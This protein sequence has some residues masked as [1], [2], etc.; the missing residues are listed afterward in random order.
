MIRA[1]PFYYT[2]TGMLIRKRRT[3]AGSLW[4]SRWQA[5]KSSGLRAVAYARQEGFDPRAAYRWRCTLRRTGQW[6]DEAGGAPAKPARGKR[7]VVTRFARIA[8]QEV[9]APTSS[10]VLAAI[11]TVF[12]QD[13]LESAIAQWR[14][15][16]E[17][18]RSKFPK[19][20]ELMDGAE[21][22]G[23]TDVVGIFSNAAAIIRLVGA[24]LLE[25]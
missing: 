15:V 5:W 22:K 3:A 25:P 21:V 2:G 20:S 10:M 4:L 13:S 7:K 16:A 23:S 8:L 18:L 1:L 6:I 11:N 24:L 9:R 19:L 17:P 14:V 12:A